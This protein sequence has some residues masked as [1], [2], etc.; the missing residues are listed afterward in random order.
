MENNQQKRKNSGLI[1]LIAI[2]L[3]ITTCSGLYA[4]AKYISSQGGNATAQ[5]AKWHF[6]LKTGAYTVGGPQLLSLT[7][8]D[9]NSHVETGKLAPGTSG[10]L[11]IIVETTG[12]ETDLTYDVTITINNCPQ[13]VVFTPQTPDSTTQTVT[14]SGTDADPRVR[15]IRIQKYV[16]HTVTDANRLH[17][18]TVTWSWP[19]ETTTGAGVD[20]NDQIDNADSNSNSHSSRN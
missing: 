4:W 5:V 10:V 11:P 7:R 1:A 6:N 17:D 8:T 20:A 15:T 19:Y 16:P 3:I 13:N 18:E 2:L 9:G 14:G 12:T